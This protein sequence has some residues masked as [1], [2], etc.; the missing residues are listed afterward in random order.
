MSVLRKKVLWYGNQGSADA[1]EITDIEN[2]SISLG[3][4]STSNN[5]DITLKNPINK[6]ENSIINHK[7]INN[8]G[9]IKIAKDDVIEIYLAYNDNQEDIDTDTD[10]FT[11][12]DVID[13]DVMYESK[14]STIKFKCYDKTFNLLNKIWTQS[15]TITDGFTVP[16]IIQELIRNVSETGE[17]NTLIGYATNDSDTSG[18]LYT[19][20]NGMYD[21]DVRLVSQ[22]GYIQDTRP[23]GASPASYPVVSM[24]KLYKPV[25]EW[26]EELSQIEYTNHAYELTNLTNPCKLKHIYYIDRENR[27]HWYYPNNIEDYTFVTGSSNESGEIISI[28]LKNSVFDVVN[29][30]FFN[31]G[32]SLENAGMIGYYFDEGSEEGKLKIKYKP[33]EHISVN[34]KSAE[35]TEGNI[36]IG[37]DSVVT[38]TSTT[39]I[40][41][42]WTSAS[43][44]SS[45][46][47]KG[48]FFDEGIRK[49]KVLA[50]D[51]TS[52]RGSPRWKGSM[53]IKGKKV[54]AG[55][56]IKLTAY[57]IGIVDKFLRIKKVTHQVN[58]KSWVTTL[59]LEEDEKETN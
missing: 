52:N 12:A 35:V 8:D 50:R 1:V 19:N 44:A 54:I 30:V 49:A 39:P 48:A 36:T 31:A 27:F 14:K 20:G 15:I 2:I 33:Y 17:A 28:K 51:F 26:I 4:D 41:P 58:N 3:L 32:K 40:T 6:Y 53:A 23:N 34:M 22:G 25:Y 11:T 57:P 59:N 42:S 9:T 46:L 37:E 45:S 10:L 21:I 16:Q 55:E 24:G 5:V 18:T 29:C 38:V 43:Y 13:T 47:Y 7:W 56:L